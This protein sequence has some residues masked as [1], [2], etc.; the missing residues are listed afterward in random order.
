MLFIFIDLNLFSLNLNNIFHYLRIIL[1]KFVN[2][3]I[4]YLSSHPNDLEEAFRLE[5]K[6]NFI[7]FARIIE[8]NSIIRVKYAM[9]EFI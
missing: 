8:K 9:F 3:M 2:L 6:K 7:R 4:E 5:I 1:Q